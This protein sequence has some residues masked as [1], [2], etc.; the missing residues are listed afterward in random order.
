VGEP[1]SKVLECIHYPS[2]LCS[3]SLNWRSIE[4]PRV[5]GKKFKAQMLAPTLLIES[6]SAFSANVWEN[7]IKRY[8]LSQKIFLLLLATS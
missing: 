3:L 1:L 6:T 7:M 2:A 5:Y 8:S 4:Y